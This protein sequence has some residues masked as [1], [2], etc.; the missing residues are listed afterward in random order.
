MIRH[1]LPMLRRGRFL[2]GAFDEELGVKDVSWLTPAGAEMTDDNWNDG[3]ARCLG[4]LLDG[5]AQETGIRR[6]GSDLDLAHHPELPHRHGAVY[7]ARGGRRCAV[8]R[9]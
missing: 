6:V 7:A 5:R 1:A 4:V 2:T 3:N 8:G 9:G